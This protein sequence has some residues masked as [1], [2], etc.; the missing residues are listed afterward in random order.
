MFRS[1]QKIAKV[2]ILIFPLIARAAH[3]EWYIDGT[4]T[5]V[6]N[7]SVV[8]KMEKSNSELLVPKQ[9]LKEHDLR[10]GM[11]ILRNVSESEL[12]Q[13]ASI[14]SGGGSK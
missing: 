13:I 7:K 14:K 1:A 4:I 12:V 5:K 10:V 9:L 11:K 6:N 8:L 2:I 3:G